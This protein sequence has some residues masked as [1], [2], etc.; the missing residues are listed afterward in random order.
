[1]FRGVVEGN[2]A[3]GHNSNRISTSNKRDSNSNIVIVVVMVIMR[4]SFFFLDFVC[5]IIGRSAVLMKV[6]FYQVEIC[7][8][9]SRRPGSSYPSV[10][11]HIP[12][13]TPLLSSIPNIPQRGAFSIWG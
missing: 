12:S 7:E 13:P 6:A 2:G 11:P 10:P 9:E 3:H 8:I 5:L 4:V 1:M